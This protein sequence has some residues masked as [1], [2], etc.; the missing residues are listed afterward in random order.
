M[1]IIS[2]RKN[3]TY[4]VVSHA[5]F[6]ETAMNGVR[7]AK[8][9]TFITVS[10]FIMSRVMVLPHHARILRVGQKEADVDQGEEYAEQHHLPHRVK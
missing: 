9:L 1:Y 6:T 7:W 10:P 8:T 4:V 2:G 5:D 3:G